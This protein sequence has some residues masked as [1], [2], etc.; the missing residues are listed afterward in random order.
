MYK[1]TETDAEYDSIANTTVYKHKSEAEYILSL[2]V[3]ENGGNTYIAYITAQ[4][5]AND[6]GSE[7][8]L[9]KVDPTPG[10]HGMAFTNTY[11]RANDGGDTPDPVTYANLFVS[12]EL[13]GSAT[14]TGVYFPFSVKVANPDFVADPSLQEPV[15]L[16]DTYKG[17]LMTTANGSPATDGSFLSGAVSA[18]LV[19]PDDEET[20]NG[21]KY[22]YYNFTPGTARP[23]WL[24]ADQKIVFIKT[25]VGAEWQAVET[26]AT[27][28]KGTSFADYTGAVKVTVN[29]LETNLAGAKGKNVDTQPRLVGMTNTKAEFENDTAAVLPMGLDINNLPYYGLI[30]LALLALAAYVAIRARRRNQDAYN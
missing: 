3:E 26:L 29:N 11:V 18:G 4:A 2:Y 14:D 10:A 7:L 6:T 15:T 12:K 1:V 17:Y 5:L 23:I 27:N 20:L 30:L 22:Y 16:P 8:P 13:T 21:V 9:D 25:P 19:N 28:L 24:K